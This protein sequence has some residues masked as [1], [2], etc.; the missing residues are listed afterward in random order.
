MIA[1]AGLELFSV[2]ARNVGFASAVLRAL[3]WAAAGLGLP[4]AVLQLTPI[5]NGAGSY[6]VC[7]GAGGLALGGIYIL[8]MALAPGRWPADLRV[9]ASVLAVAGAAGVVVFRLALRQTA[10]PSVSVL[11]AL[12]VVT[13][14]A[15]VV[16]RAPKS[17]LWF[18][19]DHTLAP[20]PVV[21][22]A[23]DLQLAQLGESVRLL[24]ETG[25]VEA[26]A[27]ATAVAESDWSDV[28]RQAATASGEHPLGDDPARRLRR[29]RRSVADSCRRLLEIARRCEFAGETVRFRVKAVTARAAGTRHYGG[30]PEQIATVRR[31][32]SVVIVLTAEP[33]S[34]ADGAD[35]K[36]GDGEVRIGEVFGFP[37][38]YRIGGG[39]RWQ[40]LPVGVADEE[41]ARELKLTAKVDGTRRDVTT[42]ALADDPRLATI[43]HRFVDFLR[44]RAM[45]EFVA[46]TTMG[47]AEMLEFES[48]AEWATA[49]KTEE[50]FTGITRA[51]GGGAR[52]LLG[53]LDR[54]G[55]DLSDAEIS[56]KEASAQKV[57]FGPWSFGSPERLSGQSLRFTFAVR[58]GRNMPDG[59]S[60][61]G[62]YVI[63][64]GQAMRKDGRWVLLDSEMR[65]KALPRSVLTNVERERIELENHV[66]EHGTLPLGTPAPDIVLVELATGEPVRLSAWRGKVVVLEWWATWCGPCQ[67]AMTALE[68]LPAAHPEWKDRVET[69]AVSIDAEAKPARDHAAKRGWTKTTH[70]WAG[71]GETNAAAARSFR[72]NG[73]PQLY[74]IDANG[75]IVAAGHPSSLPVA[76]LVRKARLN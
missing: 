74:I 62:D 24:L 13:L 33:R 17:G 59:R 25:D 51:V 14:A 44:R 26:F 42:L 23:T 47:L 12:G 45:S 66:R 9:A 37:G 11:G 8:A 1:L 40:A 16:E 65:W 70:V 4:L 22:G 41:T 56:L 72:V 35:R 7:A 61:S 63:E 36:R 19:A 31:L 15:W 64:T 21:T 75:R 34:T 28:L 6:L 50:N 5:R 29:S 38:G 10:W 46:A 68:A 69:I 18:A 54:L 30:E 3:A 60:P 2:D 57:S 73:V 48:A 20:G 27:E 39:V 71:P 53:M 49:D 43:G 76:A 52:E 32:E 55:I 67:P 58:A